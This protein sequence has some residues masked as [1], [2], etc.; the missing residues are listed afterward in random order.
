MIDNK[1]KAA[2]KDL[3]KYLLFTSE[4]SLIEYLKKNG[5]SVG[6]RMS[7]SKKIQEYTHLQGELNAEKYRD[8]D[9]LSLV[10]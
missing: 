5:L 10:N 1:K 7:K 2:V 8:E 3:Y 6:K 4:E 9:F